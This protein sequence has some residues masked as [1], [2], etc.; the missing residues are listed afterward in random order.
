[1]VHWK[2]SDDKRFTW[3]W[4]SSKMTVFGLN[5][6]CTDWNPFIVMTGKNFIEGLKNDTLKTV[7]SSGTLKENTKKLEAFLAV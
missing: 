3:K 4:Q 7:C 5:C 2:N 6:T 1:M